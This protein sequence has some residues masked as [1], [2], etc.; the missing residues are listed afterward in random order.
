MSSTTESATTETKT[1]KEGQLIK[2]KE[3]IRLQSPLILPPDDSLETKAQ[4]FVG[5]IN[6]LNELFTTSSGGGDDKW[7][8]PSDWPA[9]PE[10][11]DNQIIILISTQW[12]TAPYESFM[13]YAYKNGDT[14]VNFDGT[15]S[16]SVNWGDGYSE[17]VELPSTAKYVNPE[18]RYYE[19]DET[20]GQPISWHSGPV[21]DNGAHVFV[22]T[23]TLPDNA[24]ISY[25]Y[26]NCDPLEIYVGKNVRFTSNIVQNQ[27]ILEHVKLFGWQPTEEN[28]VATSYGL[29]YN[30]YA[31]QCVDAT[32]PLVYLP[33][34]AFD[35][36]YNL[37]EIDLS[38]CAEI[39]SYGLYNTAI[40]A[41]TSDI[42]HTL[43]SYALGYCHNLK[44]LDTPN[45]STVGA[46]AFAQC[47]N[48]ESI[49]HAE[50]WTYSS[51]AFYDLYRWYD[52]PEKQHPQIP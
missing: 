25:Q 14:A 46:S 43:N 15:T 11:A 10:P 37:K 12:N 18:H 2:G 6:E 19:Y 32:E 40:T 52:N 26:P 21:L 9:I 7:V 34:R 3:F 36:C 17:T 41:I 48:I 49:T 22:I 30:C 23:I 47:Y 5:A 20:T 50:D 29:V 27:E 44:S 31:L 24:Y 28:H 1:Y 33:Q 13:V 38:Q 42:L 35:S 8:R 4:D 45:L 51:G 16:L 39:G